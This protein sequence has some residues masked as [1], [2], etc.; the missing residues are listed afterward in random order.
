MLSRGV[1]MLRAGDELLRTQRGN[2][3]VYCQ[4]NEISWFDWSR[5]ESQREML[6]FTREMI[7]FRRRYASLTADRFYD[8]RLVPARGIPDITWHGAPR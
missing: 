6:N 5:L 7:A 8:G 3:N 1:P 4:D 2:N